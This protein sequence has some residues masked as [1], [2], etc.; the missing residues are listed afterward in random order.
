M[1]RKLIELSGR[2]KLELRF[3][4]FVVL[5]YLFIYFLFYFSLFGF[6]FILNINLYSLLMVGG[7]WREVYVQRYDIISNAY[8]FIVFQVYCFLVDTFGC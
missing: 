8:K 7:D 1:L 4:G 3:R 6:L 2:E 5:F